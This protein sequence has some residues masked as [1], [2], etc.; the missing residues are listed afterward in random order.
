[1]V[2][3]WSLISLTYSVL[4]ILF[5]TFDGKLQFHSL[6]AAAV[7]IDGMADRNYYCQ[8]VQSESDLCYSPHEWVKFSP[9]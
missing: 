9:V 2:S 1:M 7:L 3:V 5:K 8:N 4:N 6:K